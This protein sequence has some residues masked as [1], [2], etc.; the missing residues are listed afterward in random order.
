MPGREPLDAVREI[1]RSHPEV[2]SVV[3]SGYDDQATIDC[4][5]EAGA[6]GFVSKHAEIEVFIDAVRKVARETGGPVIVQSHVRP[7]HS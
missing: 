1:A 5:L 3:Y 2:R 6:R 4:A 7:L